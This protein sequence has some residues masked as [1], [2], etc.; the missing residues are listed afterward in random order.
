MNK[1][2]ISKLNNTA[3]SLLPVLLIGGP[4]VLGQDGLKHRAVQGSLDAESSAV[5]EVL[6]EMFVYCYSQNG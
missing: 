1:I 2:L 6:P 4:L 3:P 5:K